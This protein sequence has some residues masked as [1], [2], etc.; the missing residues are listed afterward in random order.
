MLGQFEQVARIRQNFFSPGP[1]RPEVVFT[2]RLSNLDPA[3]KRFYLDI[4]GQRFDVHPGTDES[5]APVVW[6]GPR[7]PGL[8]S[9]IFEDD[10]G[11]PERAIEFRGPWAWFRLIDLANAP[12]V[13]NGASPQ[14]AD[15]ASVLRLQTKSHEVKVLIEPVTV[16]NPFAAQDWRQFK[17]DP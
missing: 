11:P 4:D 3:A 17:C 9:A 16:G 13:M 6:P 8:A 5:R 12:S 7:A 15:S 10:L 2:V 14:P 1:K